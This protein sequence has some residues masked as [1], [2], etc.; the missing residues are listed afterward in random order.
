[1][2]NK[3]RLLTETFADEA[4]ARFAQLAA[5]QAR[6]R[7]ALRQTGLAAATLALALVAGLLFSPRP[8]L[9]PAVGIAKSRM[10]SRANVEIIS[11]QEL[12]AQ[13]KDQPILVLKDRTGITGVVFLSAA[14]T[15]PKL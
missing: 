9:D 5:A 14:E 1:M 2:N 11:D 8:R 15:D 3:E 7:R 10:F 6:R 4:G 13:L 12:L